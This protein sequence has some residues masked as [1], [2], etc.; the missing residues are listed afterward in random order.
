MFSGGET[1]NFDNSNIIFFIII[2]EWDTIYQVQVPKG[3]VSCP[4]STDRDQRLSGNQ[5]GFQLL[6]PAQHIK[7][8]FFSNSAHIFVEFLD[9]YLSFFARKN[10]V[11]FL[12]LLLNILDLQILKFL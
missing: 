5:K 6:V 10:L 3:F 12:Y 1:D 4:F 2:L 7:Q 8:H 9:L 11:F